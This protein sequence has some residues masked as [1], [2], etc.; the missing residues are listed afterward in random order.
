MEAL[1]FLK[2][3]NRRYE[4][5]KFDYG[6]AINLMNLDLERLVSNVEGWVKDHPVKTR[7]TEFLKM[8]PNVPLTDDGFVD[9]CPCDLDKVEYEMCESDLSGCSECLEQFWNKE[10]E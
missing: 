4:R 10:V 8:F 5:D 3:V 9:I 2:A 7:Q 6:I 1:E